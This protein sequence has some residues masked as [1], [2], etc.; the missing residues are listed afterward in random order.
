[1]GEREFFE[2]LYDPLATTTTQNTRPIVP[3]R[4]VNP[5][6]VHR[7][8]HDGGTPLGV[9]MH[10]VRLALGGGEEPQASR[11]GSIMS[12]STVSQSVQSVSTVSQS[13]RS[14]SR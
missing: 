5:A 13:A 8:K 11:A 3:G 2:L 14:V 6:R 12:V 7:P 10:S 9:H 1:M 4:S